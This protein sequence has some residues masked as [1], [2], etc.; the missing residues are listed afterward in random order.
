MVFVD[1]AEMYLV[2][3]F[4]PCVRKNSVT[5]E[6][7]LKLFK[8]AVV[9]ADKLDHSRYLMLSIV[10]KIWNWLMLI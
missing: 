3:L 8:L 6:V 10:R 2:F 4:S 7:I 5:W 1:I 9:D